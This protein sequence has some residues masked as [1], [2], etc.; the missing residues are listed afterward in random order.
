MSDP[1]L[2]P[3]LSRFKIAEVCCAVHRCGRA[4]SAGLWCGLSSLGLFD[5][6]L[7]L[8]VSL[9]TRAASL[10]LGALLRRRRARW[11]HVTHTLLTHTDTHTHMLS[12]VCSLTT[13]RCGISLFLLFFNLAL[14]VALQFAP[15]SVLSGWVRCA[16]RGE[17]RLSLLSGPMFFVLFD[18]LATLCFVFFVFVLPCFLV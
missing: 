3:W 7:L 4:W 16:R 17:V 13:S 5:H 2:T 15:Q 11:H 18:S 12:P 14:H 9:F 8:S 10:I 6:L 1:S